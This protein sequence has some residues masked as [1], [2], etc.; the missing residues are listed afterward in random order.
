MIYAHYGREEDYQYLFSRGINVSD[1]ILLVRYGSIFR[2][3]KVQI[4]E[5]L[6]A[7][8]VILF[9]DPRDKAVEGRNFT[10]PASWWMPG[11]GVESG[12]IYVGD[13]DPLTP[14]YPA[15]GLLIHSI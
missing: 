15:L 7:K 2:G 14:F 8:G 9:T 5:K 10:Y 1:H 11:M 3:S 12:T 13:G 4:A 6:G